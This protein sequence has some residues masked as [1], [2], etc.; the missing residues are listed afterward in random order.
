MSPLATL[1]FPGNSFSVESSRGQ[2][3][4]KILPLATW[5]LPS[6]QPLSLFIHQTERSAP[7][8]KHPLNF[9]SLHL[10]ITSN[11]NVSSSYFCGGCEI[12]FRDSQGLR[13]K[14]M[15]VLKKIGAANFSLFSGFDS[16]SGSLPKNQPKLVVSKDEDVVIKSLVNLG[17]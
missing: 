5:S 17:Q 1:T 16:P 2:Q 3:P 10:L 12:F 4:K 9:L 14:D 8:E 15:K 6:L 13:W 11:C 7:G